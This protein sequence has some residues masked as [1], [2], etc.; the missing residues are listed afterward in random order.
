MTLICGADLPGFRSNT[1][2]EDK[3]QHALQ[4]QQESIPR[5]FPKEPA[6]AIKTF[7]VA[8]GFRMDLIVHEPLITSPVAIAYDEN[9]SMYVAG[10]VGFPFPEKAGEESNG[11]VRLV[12]DKDGDGTFDTSRIFADGLSSPSTVFCWKGGV[13]VGTLG[14]VWYFKDTKGSGK[15]DIRTK[16]FTG[17]GLGS[18]EYMQN[19]LTWGI[20][21]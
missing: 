2:G 11:R 15:A 19:G 9:G 13:F 6:E 20:D 17:F 12:L 16:V 4:L 7:R 1:F 8:N 18:L 21:C 14:D 10:M 3:T 5:V